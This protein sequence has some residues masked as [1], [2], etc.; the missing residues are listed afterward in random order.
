MQVIW[1]LQVCE[2]I[3]RQTFLLS[4]LVGGFS[5]GNVQLSVA[6]LSDV[7]S[8]ATRA[9]SLALVGIAFSL[10]FTIGPMLG[11][12]LASKPHH[13][14]FVGYEANICACPTK[15]YEEAYGEQTLTRH[16]SQQ[17]YC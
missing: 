13:G 8:P 14:T 10:C 7:S 5:E 1:T 3:R 16:F 2:L 9:R 12:W 11:A 17:R 6:I 4:R 15:V